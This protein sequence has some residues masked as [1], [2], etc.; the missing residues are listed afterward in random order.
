LKSRYLCGTIKLYRK[1]VLIWWKLIW[2]VGWP[3]LRELSKLGTTKPP[4]KTV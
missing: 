3:K 2:K 4:T 1:L